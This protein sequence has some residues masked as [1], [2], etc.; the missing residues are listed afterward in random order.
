MSMSD[1]KNTTMT[2]TFSDPQ[3][4]AEEENQYLQQQ[5]DEAKAAIGN[6]LSEAKSALA[7]GMDPKA[8][9]R[10]YPLIAVGSALVAGFAAAA[11][12]ISSK[13]EQELA[14]LR[15]VHEAMHPEPTAAASAGAKPGFWSSVIREAVE[16]IRPVLTTALLASFKAPPSNQQPPSPPSDPPPSG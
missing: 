10:K 1:H 13:E 11:V 4:V 15:K 7:A 5:A 9:T 2:E 14:H 6:A 3:T 8:W 16:M 12:T